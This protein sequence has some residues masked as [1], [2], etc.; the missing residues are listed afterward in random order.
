MEGVAEQACVLLADLL[1]ERPEQEQFLLSALIGKI[2]HPK[3]KV[4][5]AVTKQ[6][7]RLL[8][9]HPNMRLTVA[10]ELERLIFRSV[11]PL[12]FQVD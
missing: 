6:L 8:S 9:R 5:I 2:G 10:L 4:D 11:F 7:E 3:K 12:F 1:I